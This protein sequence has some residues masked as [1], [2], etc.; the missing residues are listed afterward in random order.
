MG[1]RIKTCNVPLLT[2]EDRKST[3]IQHAAHIASLG[4][5]E[6]QMQAFARTSTRLPHINTNFSGKTLHIATLHQ[7]TIGE[8]L[9]ELQGRDK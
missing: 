3:Q 6:L 7:P 1:N 4:I 5:G 9:H 8:G 2:I